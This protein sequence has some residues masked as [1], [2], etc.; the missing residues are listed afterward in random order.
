MA[1][2]CKIN[3]ISSMF[4]LHEWRKKRFY[5]LETMF[6]DHSKRQPIPALQVVPDIKNRHQRNRMIK[7]ILIPRSS[8]KSMMFTSDD[9]KQLKLL[10]HN[11]LFYIIY[12]EV[13]RLAAILT[14]LN[15][16]VNTFYS[17]IRSLNDCQFQRICYLFYREDNK[18]VRK[19]LW[20]NI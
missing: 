13:G 12:L 15:T 1:L 19:L 9:C 20:G 2:G 11:S 3:Y 6:M 10:S 17:Q 4:V 14:S 16:K 7:K 5:L 8:Y 18:H